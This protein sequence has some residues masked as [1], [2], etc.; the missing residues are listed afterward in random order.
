MRLRWGQTGGVVAFVSFGR[1]GEIS[2]VES[3]E[4]Q[5]AMVFEEWISLSK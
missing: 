3:L 4:K 2:G 1:K 5:G